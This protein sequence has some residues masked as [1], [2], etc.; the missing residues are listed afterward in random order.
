MEPLLN[1]TIVQKANWPK[2]A[3]QNLAKYNFGKLG[4]SLACGQQWNTNTCHLSGSFL[5][6]RGSQRG[7]RQDF[8]NGPTKIFF[9]IFIINNKL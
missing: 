1:Y 9:K 5:Y 6:G 7:A 8:L 4:R 2:L 3:C